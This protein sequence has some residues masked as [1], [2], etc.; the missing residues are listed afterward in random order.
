MCLWGHVQVG[1][2]RFNPNEIASVGF[3]ATSRVTPL[4]LAVRPDGAVIYFRCGL[5]PFRFSSSNELSN[6]PT[7]I[8][9]Y[10]IR[11]HASATYLFGYNHHLVGRGFY[12][13]LLL[14]GRERDRWDC[15]G[16]G[17][18]LLRYVRSFGI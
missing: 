5:F 3:V 10:R 1:T 18:G 11:F 12:L 9:R 7:F 6:R 17:C 15:P 13:R 14:D 16:T 8:G 4:N 2:L